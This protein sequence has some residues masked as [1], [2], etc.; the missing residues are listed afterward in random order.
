[1]YYSKVN[2]HTSDYTRTIQRQ[3]KRKKKKNTKCPDSVHLQ[4]YTH[5]LGCTITAPYRYRSQEDC[6]LRCL[7]KSRWTILDTNITNERMTF[8][9]VSLQ[10]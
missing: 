7:I 8:A 2:T 10:M 6:L 1:M 9:R 4:L 5:C 3:A